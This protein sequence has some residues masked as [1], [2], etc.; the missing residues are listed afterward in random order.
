MADK[1]SVFE[2]GL[3]LRSLAET[4]DL[5]RR[6]APRL[7]VGDTVALKG[8]LGAG[9]TAMARAILRSLGIVGEIPSPSFTLVQ[10]YETPSMNIVHCDLYR[11]SDST[12][13]AELGL[14]EALHDGALLVE[15][16]E[17]ARSNIPGDALWIEMDI[18]GENERHVK[19]SG[20]ARWAFLR[21]KEGAPP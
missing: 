18:A 16:P 20:P 4:E 15:W 6:I 11:I 13:L 1:L 10:E 21:E 19:L 14:E 7:R 2:G 12:Q 17:R 9:K 5:A 3:L 8:E